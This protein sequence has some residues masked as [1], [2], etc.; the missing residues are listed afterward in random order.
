MGNF[1]KGGDPS[2]F[3]SA[4]VSASLTS[5]SFGVLFARARVV[6]RCPRVNNKLCLVL[7]ICCL[8]HYLSTRAASTSS[9]AA[10]THELIKQISAET[11][12]YPV[13]VASKVR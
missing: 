5:L 1:G 7:C 2:I 9:S 6:S 11:K 13:W 4:S 10:E 3:L 12:Q 8:T